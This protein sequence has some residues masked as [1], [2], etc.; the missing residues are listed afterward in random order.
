MVGLLIAVLLC[1]P[2][3]GPPVREVGRALKGERL[4]WLPPLSPRRKQFDERRGTE[5]AAKAE[6]AKAEVAVAKAAVHLAEARL[7]RYRVD[8]AEAAAALLREPAA[9]EAPSEPLPPEAGTTEPADK[10]AE[11]ESNDEAEAADRVLVLRAWAEVIGEGIAGAS[12]RGASASARN[13]ARAVSTSAAAEE[14]AAPSAAPSA[15]QTMPAVAYLLLGASPAFVAAAALLLAPGLPAP[16]PELAAAV[17][18]AR[19]SLLAGDAE[20]QA[21]SRLRQARRALQEESAALLGQ[22]Q[23]G[24]EAEV[25]GGRDATVRALAAEPPPQPWS[26]AVCHRRAAPLRYSPP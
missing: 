13:S 23:G 26:S 6:V 18:S 1:S 8:V 17:A 24:G 25:C 14:A 19:A 20:E 5:N 22:I 12:A 7:A 9:S 2:A 16:P 21:G 4:S 11:D 10:S 15:A 3:L